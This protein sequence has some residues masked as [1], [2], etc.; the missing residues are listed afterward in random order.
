MSFADKSNRQPKIDYDGKVIIP[1][2]ESKA[3]ELAR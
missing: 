2:D 1:E 3:E